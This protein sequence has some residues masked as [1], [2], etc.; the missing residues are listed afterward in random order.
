MTLRIGLVSDT[1]YPD[2]CTELP[3]SLFSALEG[4]ELILHAGDVGDLVVLDQLGAV[5]PVVGVHGNDDSEE[6]RSSLPYKTVI[7]AGGMRIF[8]WHS[9]Y[10]DRQQEFASRQEDEFLPKLQRSADLANAAGASIAVFGHW[11]IP[12]VREVDGVT[13]INPGAVAS[14]NEVTRQLHQTVAILEIDDAGAATVRHIDLS[15][16]TV[17]FDP[18][19][20][21]DT[22]LTATLQRF[23]SSIFST[24]LLSKLHTVLGG[25]TREDQETLR[26]FVYQLARRCWAGEFS[27]ID[28]NLI[29]TELAAEPSI[30]RRDKERFGEL[31][32]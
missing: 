31:L 1:H 12:L 13:I 20:D 17:D 30:S 25:I 8:L 3:S 21:W 18:Q 24:E 19:I 22:G 2:R 29:R 27:E 11:H 26:P 14:G 28:A 16:L 6:S 9:H 10:E 4:V 32:G 5:A 15:D 7:A 23:T